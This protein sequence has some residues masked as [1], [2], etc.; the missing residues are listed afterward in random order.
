MK[1]LVKLES[2]KH[3][4]LIDAIVVY[5]VPVEIEDVKKLLKPLFLL[6]N[7]MLLTNQCEELSNFLG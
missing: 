7:A 4:I 2:D 1:Y 5:L 3:E 6:I